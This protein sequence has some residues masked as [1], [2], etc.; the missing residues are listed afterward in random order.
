LTLFARLPIFLGNQETKKIS[1]TDSQTIQEVA[2][3]LIPVALLFLGCF[4]E[5]LIDRDGWRPKHFFVGLDL[6]IYFLATCLVNVL[7]IARDRNPPPNGYVWTVCLIVIALLCLF[8]QMTVHQDWE[9][10]E[11]KG[12]KQTFMLCGVSNVIGLGLL[13]GFMRLKMHGAI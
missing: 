3:Y 11:M 13:Y 9:K 8:Y 4:T 2:A 5:K 7:D 6:T 1:P 10:D 12:K